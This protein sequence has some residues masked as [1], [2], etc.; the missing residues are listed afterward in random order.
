VE[1]DPSCV[2]AHWNRGLCRL[3]LGDWE[4]G[5][6]G[7]EWRWRRGARETLPRDFAQTLWLGAE[8]VAG[9]TILLWGEQGLGD[10]IQFARY[11]PKV[12]ARGATVILEVYPSLAP[13]LAGLDNVQ[14]VPR[15]EPPPPFDLQCP[16]MSLPLALGEPRPAAE[17]AAYLRPPPE[18]A[19]AWGERLGPRRAFR[20]GLVAS[21]SATHGR[22]A[23]RSIPF[24]TLAASL[25]Q[26]PEYHLLQNEI[27][28]A[29]RPALA[30]R[31]DVR[32]WAE[33]IGDF[34]DTAALAAQMDL[35]VSV[36]TSVAHLAGAVGRPTWALLAH[37]PDWR[38][39]LTAEAADWYA[40]MRLYR[41][42]VRGDWTAPLERLAEDLSAAAAGW[43][44]PARPAEP[45]CPSMA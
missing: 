6:A 30:A 18:R 26:G 29:D 5:W 19:A 7:Y 10:C 27:R 2:D 20:V 36:D 39:G 41:Q 4:G 24:A 22:D 21:G 38:W 37:D 8:D 28:E 14:V 17:P 15:G 16:L 13:L 34:A 25:P 3:L 23:Q 44:P 40:Q 42:A 33:A 32:V 35:V 12:A 45:P 43:S 9:R 1:L 31:P 11:A